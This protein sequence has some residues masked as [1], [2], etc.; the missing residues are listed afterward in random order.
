MNH[1][2]RHCRSAA[3]G[4]LT[5]LALQPTAEAAGIAFRNDLPAP[6][7]V[8]VASITKNV[9]RRGRPILV[10]PS[11]VTVERMIPPGKVLI[12]VYD[13]NRPSRVLFQDTIIFPGKDLFLALQL[14]P[15]PSP[16][17]TEKEEQAA[18]APTSRIRLLPAKVVPA[19]IPPPPPKPPAK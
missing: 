18:K 1:P 3:L 11:R 8:Q 4:L 12:S 7:I 13:A 15:P 9:V 10:L 6:V 5:L 2:L 14:E 17:P 19:N 16:P